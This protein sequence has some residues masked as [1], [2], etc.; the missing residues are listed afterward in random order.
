MTLSEKLYYKKCEEIA[1]SLDVGEIEAVQSLF[2]SGPLF[3]GE[4]ISPNLMKRLL[5]RNLAVKIVIEGEDGYNA[6]THTGAWVWRYL[7][8]LNSPK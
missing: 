2:E 8:H 4:T 6:C 3:D 5:D 7:K 1:L